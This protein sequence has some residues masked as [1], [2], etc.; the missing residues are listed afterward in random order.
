MAYH[1]ERSGYVDNLRDNQWLLL[2][3]ATH[4]LNK[5][6]ELPGQ[7]VYSFLLGHDEAIK[8]HKYITLLWVPFHIA[9]VEQFSELG[10]RRRDNVVDISKNAQGADNI[11][12]N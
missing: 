4:M 6:Q 8:S 12:D 1:H 2:F 11:V 9:L 3:R 10:Y 7:M 5:Q